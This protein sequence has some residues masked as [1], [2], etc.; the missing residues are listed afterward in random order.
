MQ[1]VWAAVELSPA[2]SVTQQAFN[3]EWSCEE[4]QPLTS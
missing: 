1:L 3:A 4:S 2:E